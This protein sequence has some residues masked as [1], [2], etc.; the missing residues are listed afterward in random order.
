MMAL[1]DIKVENL[2]DYVGKSR[3]WSEYLSFSQSSSKP[4]FGLH[5][6]IFIQPFLSLV[7]SGRK[8]IE[9]RFSTRRV[10]PFNA[11]GSGD[12]ILLKE[13]G[14]PIV[15]LT[16]AKRTWFY[17]NPQMN[18]ELI[19]SKYSVRL[20]AEEDA[21]WNSRKHAAYATLIEL[22]QPH[23]IDPIF[24]D[25]RDR[26]GWVTLTHNQVLSNIGT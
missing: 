8:T 11:V 13:S 18:L 7:L 3:F 22:W 15:G 21:F 24:C 12:V 4:T 1:E 5:L 10:S 23:P 6:A 16:Q 9:S 20:C 17:Q 2:F 14:G 25:K 26:R 19:R